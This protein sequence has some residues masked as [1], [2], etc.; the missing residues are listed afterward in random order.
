MI[1]CGIINAQAF[2]I[3]INDLMLHLL[4]LLKNIFIFIGNTCRTLNEMLQMKLQIAR[5]LL[6]VG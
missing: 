5:M 4:S 3:H 1:K 6:K 2:F